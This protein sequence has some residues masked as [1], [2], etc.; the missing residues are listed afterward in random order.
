MAKVIKMQN[1]FDRMASASI[2]FEPYMEMYDELIDTVQAAKDMFLDMNVAFREAADE[3]GIAPEEFEFNQDAVD[4]TYEK[5][6]EWFMPPEDMPGKEIFYELM[7]EAHKGGYEYQITTRK[8]TVYVDREAP[9]EI[10]ISREK[11]IAPI[12]FY[13]YAKKK[14]EEC[15]WRE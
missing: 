3:I 15:N 12:E 2:G 6:L 14:W 4:E 5:T 8:N 7:W 11:K 13:D 10:L 9:I 1:I